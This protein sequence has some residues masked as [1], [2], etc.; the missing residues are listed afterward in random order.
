MEGAP[1]S[2]HLRAHLP[3]GAAHEHDRTGTSPIAISSQVC[4]IYYASKNTLEFLISEAS[5]EMNFGEDTP[6]IVPLKE[7]ISQEA[8]V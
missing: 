4:S 3:L 1:R 5:P 6:V 7:C 2:R 8:A